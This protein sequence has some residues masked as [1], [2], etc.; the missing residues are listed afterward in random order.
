MSNIQIN[1]VNHTLLIALARPD[2]RNA[3]TADM[4]AEMAT[5]LRE[6]N[7]NNDVRAVLI[8]GVGEH[9][10]AGNDLSDFA[11]TEGKEG[12]SS[13]FDFM[14]ALMECPLPVVVK[15]RGQAVGIGTTLLLHSDLV[16]CT[17]DAIFTMPFI[18]LGLVPEYA[19]SLL[20][21]KMLGHQKA[22]ELLM[23]GKPFGAQE[24]LAMGFVNEVVAADQLD[25]Q[26]NKVLA[27]L[28]A[29][30]KEAMRLTKS[31]MKSDSQAVQAHMDNEID[32]FF[33]RL[34]SEPAREAFAAFLEKRTPDPAKYR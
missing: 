14:R 19:S 13:T 29:K 5:A 17:D 28:I 23:L 18:T 12:A 21:P 1:I 9:F 16:Y 7:S 33:E 31:L 22:A 2:K 10:T 26:V 20:L 25:E 8:E 3:L 30:P 27:Q 6:V 34:T 24:A 15:V 32:I 11:Q 4:Y